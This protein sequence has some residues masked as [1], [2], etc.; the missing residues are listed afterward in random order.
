MSSLMTLRER[1]VVHLDTAPKD[2]WGQR[3]ETVSKVVRQ[4]I[5]LPLLREVEEE[6]RPVLCSPDFIGTEGG[7]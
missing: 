1:E 4:P 6:G 7:G 5:L 3:A 2:G